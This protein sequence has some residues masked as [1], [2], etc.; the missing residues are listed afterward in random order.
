M[1]QPE[2]S[3]L[4]LGVGRLSHEKNFSMLIR[5]FALVRQS[6]Q[7]KLLIL[8]EGEERGNLE[9]LSEALGVSDYVVMPGFVKNP[10]PYMARAS[11]FVSPSLYEGLSNVIIESLA[12][13]LPVVSTRCPGGPADIL[14]NGRAGPLVPVDDDR[15]MADAILAML[16][17]RELASTYLAEGQRGL[18]RF[19]PETSIGKYVELVESDTTVPEKEVARAM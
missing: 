14:L 12:L 1:L 7:C 16:R 5:A 2:D 3:P 17:D 6:M 19:R 13:G 4:I 9:A 8:G 18:D 11:L 15:A 10:Y